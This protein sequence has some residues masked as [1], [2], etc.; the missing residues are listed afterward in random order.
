M[1]VAV[2][3]PGA[4]SRQGKWIH[5]A[6]EGGQLVAGLLVVL[7]FVLA[8]CRSSSPDVAGTPPPSE[9]PSTS[10]PSTPAVPAPA[11][12]VS[13]APDTPGG[14]AAPADADRPLAARINGA[15]IYLDVY[16]KQVAQ[17]QRA[18]ADQGL[19]LEGEEGQAQLSQVR[20][21]VL[22]ALIE[23]AI[24]EQ[25]ASRAGIVVT[26]EE[27]E[28]SVQESVALGQGQGSFDQWL[29]ENDMTM[30]EFRATQRAQLLA[31]KMIEEVTTQVPTTA[32]QVHARHILVSD[33]DRAE[34]LLQELHTGANFAAL[35]Q[36]VSE[37]ASTAANG[38][39]LGWFP[40]DVPLMPPVVVEAAFALNP[41]EI[42]R[43][44]ESDQGYHIIKVEA[45]EPNRPLAPDILLYIRQRAFEEWLVERRDQATIERYV[46]F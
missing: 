43:V 44:I 31:S 3:P 20:Q 36:Q 16:E 4:I 18:L 30:E 14:Q 28:T 17:T 5:L 46:E 24:I 21:N 27:V 11:D 8:G 38:G 15:P 26:D 2:R 12:A 22:N 32:E 29:A 39:D 9:A 10:M 45:R 34:A 19:L 37:D 7:M 23:Q 33:Q 6:P 42:G 35:A 1:P 13:P 40:R 25:E 41:G